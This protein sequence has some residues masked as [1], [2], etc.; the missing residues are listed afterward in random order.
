[1]HSQTDVVNELCKDAGIPPVSERPIEDHC[2]H[3]KTFCG[4]GM[5]TVDY[6]ENYWCPVCNE[7]IDMGCAGD[8][9]ECCKQPCNGEAA[10]GYES[11]SSSLSR[12]DEYMVV[13]RNLAA[14]LENEAKVQLCTGCN[15][16]PDED[17]FCDGICFC[18]YLKQQ[19]QQ[20]EALPSSQDDDAEYD[21]ALHSAT[22]C[23][24]C[25]EEASGNLDDGICGE[26]QKVLQPPKKPCCTVWKELSKE[27]VS[28]IVVNRCLQGAVSITT[29]NLEKLG[30][31]D[32]VKMP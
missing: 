9:N 4:N 26:C 2:D 1:M 21:A 3:P 27:T 29:P 23:G 5:V 13:P 6:V 17:G 19:R 7:K 25:G 31:E 10:T 24:A 22:A 20:E 18:C 30:N 11:S 12:E 15:A 16:E 32:M 14:D 28:R 8:C